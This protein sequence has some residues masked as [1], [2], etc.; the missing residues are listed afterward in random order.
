MADHEEG[1]YIRQNTAY[2]RDRGRDDQD[3]ER[4]DDARP[5]T[6]IWWGSIDSSIESVETLR[7]D[8]KGVMGRIVYKS[9]EISSGLGQSY[10]YVLLSGR[11]SDRKKKTVSVS[12]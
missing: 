7:R 2:E 11:S 4:H 10:Q 1:F 3:E 6:D 9:P 12:A 5:R 8:A